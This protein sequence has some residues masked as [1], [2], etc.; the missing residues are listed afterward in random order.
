M[1]IG[2]LG[3]PKKIIRN[4]FDGRIE[5]DEFDG[6]GNPLQN[7]GQA[8]EGTDV[9]TLA[10]VEGM[11]AELP[12]GEAEVKREEYEGLEERVDDLEVTRGIPQIPEI[13]AVRAGR[14]DLNGEAPVQVRF[15]EALPPEIMGDEVAP[16]DVGTSGFT[17]VGTADGGSQKTAT[18]TF[19]AGHHLSGEDPATNLTAE[20]DT[21][22]LIAVDEDVD[23]EEFKLVQLDNTSLDSGAAIAA[24]MET[25]IQALGGIYAAVTVAYQTTPN[26]L[27]ITSGTKGTGSK[28]AVTNAP[29]KDVCDE[30]KIGDDGVSTDGTGNV[31]NGD[32]VTIEE[33][34][35]VIGA[36]FTTFDV[37]EGEGADE[38]RIVLRS[39]KA[40][41]TASVLIGSGTGSAALGFTPT[42]VVYGEKGLGYET[43]M[44]D[45][46]YFVIP[47]MEGTA[48]ESLGDMELSI[49][50]KTP[51]GFK[52]AC[53]TLAA[54]ETVAFVIFGVAAEP[55]EE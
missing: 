40:D 17:L 16:F 47:V 20:V 42:D 5:F 28:V 15:K 50:D 22:F 43:D 45:S 41:E 36:A 14:I 4:L 1:G 24:E 19:V 35:D 6:G 33:A 29:S 32:A 10:Q 3:F 8:A 44:E 18:F 21:S 13:M 53:E 55:V 31:A 11:L 52:I 27:K 25:K 39:K 26:H 9:P 12:G 37:V 30:L 7:V 46:E 2:F 38:G 48:Q 49:I 34:L 54:T 51:S 23:A